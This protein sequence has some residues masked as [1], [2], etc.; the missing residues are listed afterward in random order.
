MVCHVR[1][2]NKR[3]VC[4]GACDVARVAF[5][6]V[7]IVVVMENDCRQAKSFAEACGCLFRLKRSA[8]GV[9]DLTVRCRS[10]ARMSRICRICRIFPVSRSEIRQENHPERS[11]GDK[12]R[13]VHAQNEAESKCLKAKGV[14]KQ[15]AQQPLFLRFF[16]SG[17]RILH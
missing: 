12:Q 14:D 6:S 5:P 13:S 15:T 8:V 16:Y 2:H 9:E 3:S 10:R 1:P 11:T 7:C 4:Y 17:Q